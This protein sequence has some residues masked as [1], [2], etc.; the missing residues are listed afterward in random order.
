MPR[1]KDMYPKKHLTPADL[2]K[3]S[4]NI[5]IERINQVEVFDQKLN[6]TKKVWAMFFKGKNKYMIMNQT[7][8]NKL[9]EIFDSDD[10]DD[11]VGNKIVIYVD[12]ITVGGQ[13]KKALRFTDSPDQDTVEQTSG[14]GDYEKDF[15][16]QESPEQKRERMIAEA[17]Q[18]NQADKKAAA[19]G[20]NNW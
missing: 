19:T 1:V 11:W 5:T 13:P 16:P 6:R 7:N 17:S 12:N 15:T 4:V 14:Q 18:K 2:G 3:N 9:A 10:S 20:N 8:A